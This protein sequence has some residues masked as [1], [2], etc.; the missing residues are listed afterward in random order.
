MKK[1]T[2]FSLITANLVPIL[3]I[4]LLDWDLFSILFFY[5]LESA[6]V[7]IYNILRMAMANPDTKDESG[8]ITTTRKSHK[9][10]G[11]IFFL[12]HYSAF[13][14]GHGFFIFEL[15]SPVEVKMTT[16]VLGIV[17]LSISHGISFVI[18][19]I[20]HKEYKKISLSEQMIAPYKRIMVMQITIII[21]GFLLTLISSP[22]IT[23]IL[24]ILL[25]IVIDIYAHQREHYKLGTYVKG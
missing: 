22:Q 23:L 14:V 10:S 1:Y 19:F 5:W 8:K 11:I 4:F 24:L 12:I 21:C 13:M 18:N 7:G 3:G 9:I 15:F 16:V 25:K 6:V 2:L 17:S 20:G